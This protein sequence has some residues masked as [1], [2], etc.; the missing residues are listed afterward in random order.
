MIFVHF[1]V[2]HKEKMSTL[3][4]DV[5]VSVQITIQSK[6]KKANKKYTLHFMDVKNVHFQ[7]YLKLN[8]TQ[9]S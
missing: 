4:K 1:E 8:F 6:E 2:V 3:K 5:Y 9:T 7:H